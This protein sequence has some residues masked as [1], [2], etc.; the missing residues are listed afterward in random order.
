[1]NELT[2]YGLAKTVYFKHTDQELSNLLRSGDGSAFKELY[3]RYWDV[4]LD[5]AFKRLGSIEQAE[6]LVQDIFVNLFVKRENLVIESSFEGYLKNALKFKIFDFFRHQASHNKYVEN[7]LKGLHERTISPEEALQ[8]KELKERIDKTIQNIPEKCR[9][10]Y[11][12]SRVEHISNR[13]IAKKLGISVSTVEKHIN[14][15]TNILKKDFG[16][17]YFEVIALILCI[18]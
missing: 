9:E 8:I 18:Y 7:L 15:A 14:K 16:R 1:M 5:T 3:D 11:L 2:T 17:Y 4:L 10:V 13:M 6:E 12:M